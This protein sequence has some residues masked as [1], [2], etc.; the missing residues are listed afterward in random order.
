VCDAPESCDGTGT[1]CPNDDK[2]TAECRAAAGVCDVAETCDGV[3]DECPADAVQPSGTSCRPGAGVCDVAE[4]CD[5]AATACPADAFRPATDECR[6][7]AGACDVAES[8][9]GTGADCPAD[10][11]QPTT[12]VCRPAAGDCDAAETCSG[13]SVDC[14][15]DELSGPAVTCRIAAGPCDVAE[16]CNGMDSACPPDQLQAATFICR[17]STGTCD[18]EETCAG[19]SACPAD[20][21]EPDT[22]GDDVCDSTDSCPLDADAGQADGDGDGLGDACDPCNNIVPV[23]TSRSK[24]RI[25]GLT[26]PPG[27]DRFLFKG[28]MTVP[29]TPTIDPATNG[30]RLLVD[31]AGANVLDVTIPGGTGWKT[32]KSGK[33][34][35]YTNPAGGPGGIY[36]V[37]LKH[38]VKKPGTLKFRVLGRSG[39]LAVTRARIPVKGTL[40]VDSPMAQTGQCGETPYDVSRCRFSRSGGTLRCR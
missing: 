14:P 2:S 12:Q 19:D 32:S 26:T 40:I 10:A 30:I 33:S 31:D 29:T 27:D 5:G 38:Q 11:L 9:P 21:G 34:W 35:R 36:K 25:K 16:G 22:D 17:P 15:A 13:S 18:P 23:F 24:I 8:C 37:R 1:A 39:T 28:K 3:A 20:I 7:S 6:A 4:T